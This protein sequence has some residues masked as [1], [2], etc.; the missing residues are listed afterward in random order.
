MGVGLAAVVQQEAHDL[1]VAHL[2]CDVEHCFPCRAV[3][4][5]DVTAML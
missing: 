2:G 5:P 4:F 3:T 1:G